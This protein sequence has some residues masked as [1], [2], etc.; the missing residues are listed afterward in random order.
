MTKFPTWRNLLLSTV[1]NSKEI[2]VSDMRVLNVYAKQ[3]T[4][5]YEERSE[6]YRL[7]DYLIEWLCKKGYCLSVSEQ[8][9]TI[10]C[11]NDLHLWSRGTGEDGNYCEV[12]DGTGIYKKTELY[13]YNFMMDN[14]SWGWH[15]PRSRAISIPSI[16][17]IKED[18]S[19]SAKH[20][21]LNEYGDVAQRIWNV[22]VFLLLNGT[23]KPDYRRAY[24]S[25]KTSL[26]YKMF[27]LVSKVKKVVRRE[28]EDMP[29]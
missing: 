4:T 27:M 5:F 13:L 25:A 7:K 20:H 15:Q 6:I 18:E 9:Q 24:L 29:F 28:K 23:I 10:E 3:S 21:Q 14:R 16:G 22:R 19:Y 12:C 1:F 2:V 17:E 8:T 11:N 26:I